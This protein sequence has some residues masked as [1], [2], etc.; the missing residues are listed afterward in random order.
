MKI[1]GYIVTTIF[2]IVFSPIA[3]GLA[4]IVGYLTADTTKKPDTKDTFN[5]V[6]IYSL[7]LMIFKTGSALLFGSIVKC[8][9]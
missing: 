6:L 3:N 1:I 7:L 5:Q 9:M 4:L 8:W 2:I